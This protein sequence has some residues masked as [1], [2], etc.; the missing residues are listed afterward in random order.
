[1]KLAKRVGVW[2]IALAVFA[3]ALPACFATREPGLPSPGSNTDWNSPTDP[4]ILIANFSQAMATLNLVNYERC[5][6]R[7]RFK[8]IV[9]P[10]ISGNNVGA[11]QRWT[12]QEELDY[13]KN[14]RARS[15]NTTANSLAF[16]NQRR[17]NLSADSIEYSAAY[18]LRAYQN[19]TTFKYDTFRGNAL[20]VLTRNRNNEWQI[21]Q[22]Q[23]NK[24]TGPACWSDLKQRFYT[25]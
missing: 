7:D 13:I 25:P 19:D 12:L 21:V 2:A 5:L 11:F 22:W 6:A 1:M 9:E 3:L 18:E 24:S 16:S 14:L 17:N 15:T 8:F 10:T 20:L 23:D 4:D